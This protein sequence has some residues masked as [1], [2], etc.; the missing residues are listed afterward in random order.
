MIRVRLRE[1]KLCADRNAHPCRPREHDGIFADEIFVHGGVTATA[2]LAGRDGERRLGQRVELGVG[3]FHRAVL[4]HL[5]H[6]LVRDALQ[7]EDFLLADAEQVIVVARALDDGLRRA[8]HAGGVIDIDGRIAGAGADG[9]L[10]GLHRG[11]HDAGTA[12]DEQDADSVVLAH[13]GEALHRGLL[14]DGRD[15]L[16]AGLAK[17]RL[18]VGAHCDRRAT[19]RARM[20]VEHD[21]ISRRA[22]VHDVAAQCRNRMRARRDRAHDAEGRVFLQRDA[23]IAAAGVGPEPFHAGDEL[24][25]LQ[26]LD[27]VIEPANLRLVEFEFAPHFRVGLRHRLDDLD[28][29]HARRDAGLLELQEGFLRGGA[30][31]IGVGVHAELAACSGRGGVALAIAAAVCLRGGSRGGSFRGRRATEAAQHFT[32]DVSN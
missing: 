25:N 28:D 27:L 23:V 9:A 30:G 10:A 20:R 26:L 22:D 17:D 15:V 12:G 32:D 24:D 18:V 6:Q 11:L 29:L 4:R 16:N 14:D 5:L 21:G 19:R 1:E 13:R 8:L 3:E 7:R 2:A 31:F